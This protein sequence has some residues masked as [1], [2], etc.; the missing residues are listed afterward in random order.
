MP[1]STTKTT[2]TIVEVRSPPTSSVERTSSTPDGTSAGVTGTATTLGGTGGVTD[3]GATVPSVIDVAGCS[4]TGTATTDVVTTM[5]AQAKAVA[6]QS[7]PALLCASPA[8]EVMLLK[9]ALISGYGSS[10]SEP[11]LLAG[12]LLIN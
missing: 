5:T 2:L 1:S 3:G 4:H 8:R 10:E 12:Q 11:S 6:V 7:L 9:M